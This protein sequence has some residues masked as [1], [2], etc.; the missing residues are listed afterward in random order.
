[1]NDRIREEREAIRQLAADPEYQARRD[2]EHLELRLERANVPRKLWDVSMDRIP[3]TAKHKPLLQKWGRLLLKRRAQGEPLPGLLL[4]GPPGSGKTSI[5]AGFLRWAMGHHF[6]VYFIE[7]RRLYEVYRDR[8]PYHESAPD[9]SVWEAS[10]QT[11]VTVVDDL[12]AGHT[13][14]FGEIGLNV[15][16]ELLRERTGEGKA[17]IVTSNFSLEA[18]G[19]ANGRVAHQLTESCYDVKVEGLDY[20]KALARKR[21]EDV[22]V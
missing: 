18:I 21:L 8:P 19:E 5:A 20:R 12:L 16:D 11:D 10:L 4:Y 6:T 15:F 2:R 1:M 13:E 22:D 17:T 3:D 14:R 9:L 7:Y